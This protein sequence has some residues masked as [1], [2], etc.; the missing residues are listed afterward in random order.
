M[1]GDGT[2]NEVIQGII[3]SESGTP[4][5]YIPAGSTNDFASSLGL[6]RAQ[7]KQQNIL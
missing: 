4:L 2:L 6:K 7:R 3:E 5:G 1:G